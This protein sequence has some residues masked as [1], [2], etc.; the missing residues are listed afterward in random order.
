MQAQGRGAVEG[1][2]FW[3]LAGDTV[4]VVQPCPTGACLEDAWLVY[5]EKGNAVLGMCLFFSR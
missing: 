1:G 3:A 2:C 5:S 4:G